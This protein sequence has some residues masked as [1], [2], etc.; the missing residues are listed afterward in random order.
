MGL[1]KYSIEV[2]S[3]KNATAQGL[4]L[5]ASYKDLV[6]ICNFIK[7]KPLSQIREVLLKAI[8]GT[9]AIPYKKFNKGL[10]H[11]SELG[12]KK[13]RYPKKECKIILA[14]LKQAEANAEHKGLD[15]TKLAVKH[16]AAYKQNI[17]PRSR[18][19][20]ASGA[21][22]GYGKAAFRSDYVTARV[23]L[24]LEEKD[25]PKKEKKVRKKKESGK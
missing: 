17:F 24:V 11:R 18:R 19:F 2:D 20:F 12:G 13:G 9:H 1:Y 15:K 14:L 8:K 6:N 7:G 25:F 21:V 22:L 10:G 5:N 4:D 16:A 23:E 3:Q